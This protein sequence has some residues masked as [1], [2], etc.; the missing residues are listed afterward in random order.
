MFDLISKK[1]ILKILESHGVLCDFAKHLIENM[2]TVD[3]AGIENCH[4]T[5]SVSAAS[6]TAMAKTNGLPLY[7]GR[8][9]DNGEW[10][11]GT[12]VPL[13]NGG[14]A[15]IPEGEAAFMSSGSFSFCA[16][17]SHEIDPLTVSEYTEESCKD[18]AK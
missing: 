1:E 7:R 8:R 11:H 10:V 12:L 4:E 9:L 14:K 13:E 16:C 3:F 6:K 5:D 17:I 2:P 15:I 18:D